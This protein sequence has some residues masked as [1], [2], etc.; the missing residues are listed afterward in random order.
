MFFAQKLADLAQ[1]EVQAKLPTT[2]KAAYF[3]DFPLRTFSSKI[4]TLWV[5]HGKNLK[6]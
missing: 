6:F 1:N 4:T 5:W 2:K 3:E